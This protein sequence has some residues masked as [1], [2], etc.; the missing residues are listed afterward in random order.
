MSDYYNKEGKP[1]TREEYAVKFNDKKYKVVQQGD[2]KSGF[3]ISTVWLGL[4]HS[5]DKNTKYHVIFE[6]MVFNKEKDGTLNYSGIDSRRY[7]T[8]KEATAGH[9]ELKAE[10]EKKNPIV[11]EAKEKLRDIQNQ[12]EDLRDILYE[13]SD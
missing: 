13:G 10:W 2:T 8:L 3:W 1:I 6:S 12:I 11:E 7:C 5:H 9:K 4:D